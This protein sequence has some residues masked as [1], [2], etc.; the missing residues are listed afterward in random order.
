MPLLP[1][2]ECIISFFSFETKCLILDDKNGNVSIA[3]NTSVRRNIILPW[4]VNVVLADQCLII[5]LPFAGHRQYGTLH[6]HYSSK[7]L[8]LLR[9]PDLRD[10]MQYIDSSKSLHRLSIPGTHNSACHRAALPTVRCQNHGIQYQLER[11]VRFFDIRLAKRKR[12][13]VIVHGGFPAQYQGHLSWARVH[14]V[15]QA[16]LASHVHET[17]LCSLKNEGTSTDYECFHDFDWKDWYVGTQISVLGDVRGHL[18]LIRRFDG[19]VGI[20]WDAFSIQDEYR[21]NPEQKVEAVMDFLRKDVEGM[22]ICFCSAS[23]LRHWPK[24]IAKFVNHRVYEIVLE[25]RRQTGVLV[26]DYVDDHSVGVIAM[27]WA[28]R[29]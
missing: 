14:A 11:G 6:A 26:W 23:T 17:I 22:K 20:P 9:L 21:L 4:K 2:K 8:S 5:H 24:T 16:F 28:D 29:S 19:N 18:V 10:W 15:L 7:R 12:D 13:W 1:A 25:I 3:P 27:N